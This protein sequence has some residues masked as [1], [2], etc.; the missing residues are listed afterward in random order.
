MCTNRSQ[1][2]AYLINSSIEFGLSADNRIENAKW[3]RRAR[4]N[5]R[6]PLIGMKLVSIALSI[7]FHNGSLPLSKNLAHL[8]QL[9][10]LTE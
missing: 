1:K 10:D 9:Q 4:E 5:N 7:L 6:M 8:W 2:K 3:N